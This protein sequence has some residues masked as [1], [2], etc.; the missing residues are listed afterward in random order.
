MKRILL[1]FGAIALLLTMI[2]LSCTKKDSTEPEPHSGYKRAAVIEFFTYHHC[3]NCP[4]AEAAIESVFGMHGDS[5]VVIEYHAPVAGDTLSPC[6][7]FVNNRQTLYGVTAYPTVE[8]DG[9]EEVVGGTGDLV[10]TYLNILQSRFSSRSHLNFSLLEAEFIDASSVSF[11]M[12][13]IS[14]AGLSGKLFI[15]LTEDSVVQSDSVYDFVARQVYPDENGMDFSVSENDTFGTNGSIGLSW[16]PDGNVRVAVFV[17]NTTTGEIYQGEEVPIGKPS[18]AQYEFG[19][20]LTPGTSQAGS[21]G[22]PSVFTFFVENSGTEDDDY[23]IHASEVSTVV[24]WSWMMCLGGLCK[25]PDHGHIYDTLF[26]SSQQTDSFTVEIIPNDSAGT[27][28]LNVHI[29]SAGDTT[30][31]ESFD[32]DTHIP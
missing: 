29:M 24:G 5:I 11:N 7:T 8:F 20:T 1:A 6:S 28:Q 23:M 9:V 18:A 25:I 30:L 17:Q 26:V 13:I 27:E 2:S 19:V 3:P 4:F 14:N 16:Q 22:Q 12:Q 32:I 10:S 31:M 21:P 15:V